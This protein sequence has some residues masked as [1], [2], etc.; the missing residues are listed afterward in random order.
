MAIYYVYVNILEAPRPDEWNLKDGAI[1]RIR[2]TLN[3]NRQQKRMIIRTLDE[4][5][6][7]MMNG[8]EYDGLV[9]KENQGGRN[10]LISP[11]SIE[12]NLIAQWMESNVGFRMGRMSH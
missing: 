9:H 4:I 11:K 1:S 5:H 3:L 8:L 6:K 7:C 10:I 12:A 2:S